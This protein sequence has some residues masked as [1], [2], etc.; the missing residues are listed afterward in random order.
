[1]EIQ[2]SGNRTVQIRDSRNDAIQWKDD[3]IS[4]DDELPF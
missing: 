4:D 1:M 2:V 3:P